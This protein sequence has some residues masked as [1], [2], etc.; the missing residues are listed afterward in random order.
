[1]GTDSSCNSQP[2]P[3]YLEVFIKA[4]ESQRDSARDGVHIGL[5]ETLRSRCI[6]GDKQGATQISIT[7]DN[8]VQCREASL[9]TNKGQRR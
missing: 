4:E 3:Y 5:Q 7:K 2:S 1:M 6:T 8:G 9:E